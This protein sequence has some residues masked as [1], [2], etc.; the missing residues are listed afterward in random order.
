MAIATLKAGVYDQVSVYVD[1][2]IVTYNGINYTVPQ[3]GTVVI[4]G[5]I[6]GGGA[7]VNPGSTTEVVLDISTTVINAGSSS[8]PQ[9]YVVTSAKAQTVPPSSVIARLCR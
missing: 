5:D 7:Q 1:K 4:T 2:M 3:S 9:F 8:S 6:S